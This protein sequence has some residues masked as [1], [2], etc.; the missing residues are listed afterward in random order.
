MTATAPVAISYWTIDARTIGVQVISGPPAS[1]SCAVAK[2]EET[3]DQVLIRVEC[4]SPL[5]GGGSTMAGYKYEFTV[6]L[7][8]VLGGRRVLDGLGQP[9]I[10]CDARCP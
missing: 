1:H 4:R 3:A 2:T 10:L 7:Q 5:V 8:Q 9:G 6:S